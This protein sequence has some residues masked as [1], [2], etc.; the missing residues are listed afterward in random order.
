MVF[1]KLI[2]IKLVNKNTKI[3]FL[4]LIGIKLV[5]KNT[6]MSFQ[7]PEELLIIGSFPEYSLSQNLCI[8]VAVVMPNKLFQVRERINR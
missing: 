7:S 1:L 3:T 8:D 6:K 5:N 2:V 4:K